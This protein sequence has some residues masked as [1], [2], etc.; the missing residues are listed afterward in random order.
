MMA[1]CN[2]ENSGSVTTASADHI[3]CEMKIKDYGIIKLELYPEKAPISVNNFVSL[4]KSGFYDG[5]KIH[6]VQPG[7]VIQGGDP[8]LVGKDN[9]ASIKGEFSTNGI[10]ND[11]AHTRGAL[12]MARKGNDNNS[13]SSQFFIC[14]G[15]CRASLDGKYAGF[16]YVTEG[17][18]VVDKI[19]ALCPGQGN[20]GM[21]SNPDVM[22]VIE[23]IKIVE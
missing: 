11:L 18:D 1:G 2:S 16:G 3:K 6:R 17:M 4:V 7:F 9:V 14:V 20:M 8:S 21:L 13:A 12:S 10:Q 23:Y 5:L 15:D 22:P 19:C